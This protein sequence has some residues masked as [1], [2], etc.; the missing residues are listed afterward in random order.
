MPIN[1][2]K[3]LISFDIFLCFLTFS[4]LDSQFLSDPWLMFGISHHSVPSLRFRL[5]TDLNICLFT[6]LRQSCNPYGDVWIVNWNFCTW[7]SRVYR[8]LVCGVSQFAS[9][10]LVFIWYFYLVF[11]VLFFAHTYIV[12]R[13]SYNTYITHW[14]LTT[15]QHL[16]T[17]IILCLFVCLFIRI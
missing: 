6:S 13:R 16:Y 9:F 4:G 10:N 8:M 12:A 17:Y 14:V 15:F 7:C 3:F 11:I 2:R 1:S 5:H